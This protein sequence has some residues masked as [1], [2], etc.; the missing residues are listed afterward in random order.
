MNNYKEKYKKA[1]EAAR[2]LCNITTELPLKEYMESIF[3]ELKESEDERIRKSIIEVIKES[4]EIL[5]KQNQKNM[6]AWLEK[7]DANKEYV[8]RPLAGT[9]IENAVEQALTQGNVVLAFNGFY[10]P[11]K[12]KTSEK[13]L[14]EY[15]NWVEKQVKISE[16]IKDLHKLSKKQGEQKP[17]EWSKQSIIDTLTNWLTEQITPLHKKHLNGTITEREEMF[18]AAL[19]EMRSFVNSPDFQ[20]GK[21]VS[22]DWSEEDEEIL[23]SIIEYVMPY[24]ECPDY[25]TDEEREYFYEGNKKVEWLKSLKKKLNGE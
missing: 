1:L 7:Q 6:I 15:E 8:F 21:D 25:P 20:I 18:E 9:T 2:A 13:I 14:A 10:T 19:L 24:G 4:S 11:V 3:P 17:I 22:K 23:D 5:E 16:S 12:G